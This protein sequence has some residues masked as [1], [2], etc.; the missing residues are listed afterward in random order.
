M[1][2]VEVVA[3]EEGGEFSV[4]DENMVVSGWDWG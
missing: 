3:G 4:L 2:S 1:V